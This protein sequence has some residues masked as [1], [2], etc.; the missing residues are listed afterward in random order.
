[1]KYHSGNN[2]SVSHYTMIYCTVN[3]PGVTS[4]NARHRGNYPRVSRHI[5]FYRSVNRPG[6]NHRSGYHRVNNSRAN[7]CEVIL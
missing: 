6:V 7:Y 5:V 1:M 2:S 3:C 4:P